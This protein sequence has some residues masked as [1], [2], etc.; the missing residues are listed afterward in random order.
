MKKILF[1]STALLATLTACEDYNDQFN[2]GS[3]ISDVKK[4]VAIKLEA[5]D[6]AA[7]ANNA[8]NKE[9]ALS[10]DPENGTY[11]A[12]LEA[13][14]KTGI[15]PARRKPNG[16]CRLSLQKSTRRPMPVPV[17]LFPITCIANRLLICP[18]SRT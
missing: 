2:I 6:Y 9:V 3:Q 16:S 1:I 7:V 10:K 17:S 4:G 8:T 5:S 18:T 15:S 12:A 11:V 13:I 14:G